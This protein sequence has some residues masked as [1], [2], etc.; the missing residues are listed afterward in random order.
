VPHAG[1]LDLAP[2]RPGPAAIAAYG[3]RRRASGGD[4][5]AAEAQFRAL[6]LARIIPPTNLRDGAGA[7]SRPPRCAT[8]ACGVHA[9]RRPTELGVIQAAWAGHGCRAVLLK[10]IAAD[11][12]YANAY[13]T[14][15][16]LTSCTCSDRSWL[17]N[18]GRFRELQAG[19]PAATWAGSPI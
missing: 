6:A 10:A 2:L 12:G 19:D 8:C 3:R 11:P 1:A 4:E 17:S 13:L 7:M 5:A 15:R 9:A 14:G 18:Y 16:V